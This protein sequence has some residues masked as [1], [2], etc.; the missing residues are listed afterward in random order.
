MKIFGVDALADV[1]V[2]AFDD[3]SAPCYK[4]QPYFKFGDNYDVLPGIN[5]YNI[6]NPLAKDLSSIV[7][8]TLRDNKYF[9]PTGN[10][11]NGCV[12]TSLP[13]YQSS[14]GSPIFTEDG[15]VIGIIS[16]GFI[17]P[18]GV[19]QAAFCGGC[20]A[21]TIKIILCH[22][23]DERHTNVIV[24]KFGTYLSNRKGW[25]GEIN[26]T[27]V[28]SSILFL[29]YY[30]FYHELTIQ[31]FVIQMATTYGPMKEF[32]VG[33]II[34]SMTDKSGKKINIGLSDCQFP[35]GLAL[36]T[37]DPVEESPCVI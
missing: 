25:M 15:L 33:D 8:G 31:G 3:T 29:Q 27:A 21:H 34:Y 19:T 7:R 20:G 6:S 11:L 16:F 13:V 37:Y 22:I 9:D 18:E 35:V 24:T 32:K 2:L 5:V 10:I 36:W 28:T 30:Q 23:F 1:A 17:S 14:S 12:T 4:K 26:F